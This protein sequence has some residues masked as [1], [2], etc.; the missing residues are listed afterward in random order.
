MNVFY[1]ATRRKE[2]KILLKGVKFR[3][4][5]KKWFFFC[6]DENFHYFILFDFVYLEFQISLTFHN[7]PLAYKHFQLLYDYENQLMREK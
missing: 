2:K 6:C 7:F 4:F 3:F 1:E 5:E